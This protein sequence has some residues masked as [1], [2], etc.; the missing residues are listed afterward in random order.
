MP[1]VCRYL[2]TEIAGLRLAVPAENVAAVHRRPDIVPVAATTGWFL[3][4]A[5]VQG[6]LLPISDLGLWLGL[7]RGS[8]T[9]LELAPS[10]GRAALQV[11]EVMAVVVQQPAA[12]A[13][14][15]GA[16]DAEGAAERQRARALE[17][18]HALGL[19]DGSTITHG[20]DRYF[21][22]DLAA[23]VVSPQFVDIAFACDGEHEVTA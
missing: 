13:A 5:V 16:D 15:C 20:G 14:G 9:V 2:A 4:M 6:Q 10:L 7:R 19:V 17:R 12:P 8:G 21:C 1:D 23:L 11:D 18:L 22:L 3:G